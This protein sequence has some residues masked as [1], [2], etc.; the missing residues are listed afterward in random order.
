[1]EW[2]ETGLKLAGHPRFVMFLDQSPQWQYTVTPPSF[3][4][5]R[6]QQPH[7]RDF[8]IHTI[9]TRLANADRV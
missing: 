6:H 3:T 9:Q 1:M 5:S 8:T 4:L 7:W 2:P